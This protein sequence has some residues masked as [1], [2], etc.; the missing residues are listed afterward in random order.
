MERK[1]SDRKRMK[2]DSFISSWVFET[3][4]WVEVV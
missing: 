1:L 3:G 2:F 4:K